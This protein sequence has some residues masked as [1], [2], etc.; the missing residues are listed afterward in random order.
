MANA[1]VWKNVKVSMQSA[2]AAALTI[3]SISNAS[4]AVVSTAATVPA[5]GA[6]V[7]ITAP[8]MSQ[9]H[10]RLF[11]VSGSGAGVF[12]LDGEDSTLYD[13][14]TGAAGAFQVIT[15]GN[16]I[17]SATTIQSSGGDF[18]FIDTTT[19]HDNQKSQIPGLP[20][21]LTYTLEN[22]EDAADPGQIALLAASRLQAQRAFK[23]LFQNGS[24]FLFYGYVGFAG[25]PTGQAQ[26]LVLA[27][28][29]LTVNTTVTKYAI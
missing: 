16:S 12:T 19:I 17:T 28:C 24:F 8:G 25:A 21:P 23:F 9:V 7:L 6:V 5:N 29:V 10:N 20:N 22:I 11:R 18:G 3:T 26:G 13:V 1:K 14:Y 2:I 15:L 27:Q 4:P